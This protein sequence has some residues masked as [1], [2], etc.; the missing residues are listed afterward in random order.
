MQIS[1]FSNLLFPVTCT[2]LNLDRSFGFIVVCGLDSSACCSDL[3][4][5]EFGFGSA[6]AAEIH[7]LLGTYI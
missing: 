5:D 2:I 7:V 3:T 1:A 4:F 6:A